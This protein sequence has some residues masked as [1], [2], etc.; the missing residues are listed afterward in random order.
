MNCKAGL[1]N[2]CNNRFTIQGCMYW[3]SSY[4]SKYFSC[5]VLG[6]WPVKC[7]HDSKLAGKISW[8]RDLDGSK[9]M[10]YMYSL[11]LEIFS[12]WRCKLY[13]NCL[14]VMY[15]PHVSYDIKCTW[16]WFMLNYIHSRVFALSLILF[17][18]AVM[19]GSFSLSPVSSNLLVHNSGI[20]KG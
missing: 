18:L 6:K 19:P 16:V 14:V 10:S 8:A 13:D 1:T 2:L 4:S 15:K 17:R 9:V 11:E 7:L 3:A 5:F 20:Y 12:W